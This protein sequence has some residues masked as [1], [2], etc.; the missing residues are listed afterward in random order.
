[1]GC[2]F[3]WFGR[4]GHP[5]PF[6]VSLSVELEFPSDEVVEARVIGV[7]RHIR[8]DARATKCVSPCIDLA[9]SVLTKF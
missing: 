1:M 5:S 8:V 7:H 4:Q 3:P 2:G 6:G 9:S